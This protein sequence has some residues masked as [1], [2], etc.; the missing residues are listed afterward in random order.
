MPGKSIKLDKFFGVF[1]KTCLILGFFSNPPSIN[2]FLL[3]IL[4]STGSFSCLFCNS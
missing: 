4:T 1:N 2:G 3:G